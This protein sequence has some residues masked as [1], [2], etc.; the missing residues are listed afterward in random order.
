MLLLEL[1]TN[2]SQSLEVLISGAFMVVLLLGRLKNSNLA[3][4]LRMENYEVIDTKG[5]HTKQ[6]IFTMHKFCNLFI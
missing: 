5:S 1:L 6:L 2:F 3:V 4:W